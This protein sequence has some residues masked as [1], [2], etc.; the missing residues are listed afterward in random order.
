MDARAI[1][2]SAV[3]ACETLPNAARRDVDCVVGLE[4]HKFDFSYLEFLDDMICRDLRGPEW[5][6]VLRKRREALSDFCDVDLVSGNVPTADGAYRVHVDPRSTTV[7][8]WEFYE[9]M[10]VTRDDAR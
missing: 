9:G 2:V 7:V 6:V 4:T 1:F 3:K 8:H 5:T 10:D